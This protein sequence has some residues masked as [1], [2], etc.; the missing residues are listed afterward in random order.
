MS[1]LCEQNVDDGDN[2]V[3]ATIAAIVAASVSLV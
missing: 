1:R 2:A 3:A